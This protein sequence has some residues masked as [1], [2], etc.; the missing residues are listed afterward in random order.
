VSLGGATKMAKVGQNVDIFCKS[1]CIVSWHRLWPYIIQSIYHGCVHLNFVSFVKHCCHW[2]VIFE[3]MLTLFL[4]WIYICGAL[5]GMCCFLCCQILNEWVK[6]GL[7]GLQFTWLSQH[8]VVYWTSWT[9]NWSKLMT[10]KYL[11]LMRFVDCV[12]GTAAVLCWMSKFG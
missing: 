3:L 10:V 8:Q 1:W 2:S 4:V 5:A 9:K 6:R 7:C 11:S 12:A